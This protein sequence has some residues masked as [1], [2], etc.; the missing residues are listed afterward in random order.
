MYRNS[1]LAVGAWNDEFR[2]SYMAAKNCPNLSDEDRAALIRDALYRANQAGISIKYNS[3]IR[4]VLYGV[5]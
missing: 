4:S 3:F 2:A 5:E 1:K